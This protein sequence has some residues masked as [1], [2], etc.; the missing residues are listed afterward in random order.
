MY[1]MYVRGMVPLVTLERPKAGAA[2]PV[3]NDG[4]TDAERKSH[5][6]RYR[7]TAMRSLNQDEHN[8]IA[9]WLEKRATR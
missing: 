6:A 4:L 9:E 3:G 8:A 7:A 1:G 2:T 5:E